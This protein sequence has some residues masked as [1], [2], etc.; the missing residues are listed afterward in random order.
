MRIPLKKINRALKKRFGG[1][2]Q[3]VVE[4]GVLVLRGSAED[5]DGV[6]AA[7]RLAASP[8]SRWYTVNEVTWP[9]AAQRQPKPV[10]QT[11]ESL[12]GRAPDVLLIGAGVTG[13]AIARELMRWNV[14]LL[15]V[16]KEHDVALHASSRNDGMVHPGVDLHKGTAKYH[17]NRLGNRMYGGVCAALGVPSGARDSTCGASRAEQCARFCPTLRCLG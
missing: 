15:W 6:V 5:W 3:A 14:D 4:R 2:V 16:E 10:P 9:G 13:A 1:R 11:D 8:K 7:G 12:A 17:Y